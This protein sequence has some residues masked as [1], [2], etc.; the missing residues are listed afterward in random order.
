MSAGGA[1]S[2][3]YLY[4]LYCALYKM[5]NLFINKIANLTKSDIKKIYDDLEKRDLNV[6]ETVNRSLKPEIPV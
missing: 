1:L 2:S 3:D 6:L 5:A 4:G